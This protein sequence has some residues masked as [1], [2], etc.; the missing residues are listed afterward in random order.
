MM[1]YNQTVVEEIV[2]IK[3]LSVT[4][5]VSLYWNY[6]EIIMKEITLWNA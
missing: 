1:S 2:A 6:K 4:S 3:T 5:I